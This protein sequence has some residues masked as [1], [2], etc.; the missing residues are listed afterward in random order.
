MY[1][2][3]PF[4]P[5]QMQVTALTCKFQFT[6]HFHH[7]RTMWKTAGKGKLWKQWVWF[8]LVR[9]FHLRK[10]SPWC[11][12][13][14]E[15]WVGGVERRAFNFWCFFKFVSRHNSLL[16]L[17]GLSSCSTDLS[18]SESKTSQKYWFLFLSTGHLYTLLKD[19]QL[20]VTLTVGRW[21]Y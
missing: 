14:G 19:K 8:I 13:L 15:G 17:I 9:E 20:G 2:T 3:H 1:Q 7:L 5:A 21:K 11:W 16:V 12:G 18:I 6:Y 10:V 4:H